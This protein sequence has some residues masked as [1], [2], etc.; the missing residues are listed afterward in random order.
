MKTILSSFLALAFMLQ[1]APSHALNPLGSIAAIQITGQLG[2]TGYTLVGLCKKGSQEA[3]ACL[4]SRDAIQDI[5]RKEKATCRG[6]ANHRYS[7]SKKP[8]NKLLN[9]QH[10]RC[11]DIFGKKLW[12]L[13][14]DSYTLC[15]KS[16]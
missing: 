2:V 10:A 13:S 3:T 9:Q 1:T 4:T 11:N 12:S 15:M 5:L 16:C 8:D 7:I 14:E 6:R